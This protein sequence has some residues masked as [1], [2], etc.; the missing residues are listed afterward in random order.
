MDTADYDV[1]HFDPGTL[2]SGLVDLC[3]IDFGEHARTRDPANVA[4]LVRLVDDAQKIKKVITHKVPVGD[5]ERSWEE[6]LAHLLTREIPNHMWLAMG[7]QRF[8]LKSKWTVSL[9]IK[10]DVSVAAWARPRLFEWCEENGHSDLLANLRD[11][12][13]PKAEQCHDESA[14]L[15][16][17]VCKLIRQG[18]NVP[19]FLSV[20][21]TYVA[22]I[23]LAQA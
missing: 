12:S 6:L 17:L 10:P 1:G 16:R 19:Y 11:S 22:R 21:H 15:N 13:K 23:K 14:G 9:E 7:I 4:R 3:G 5:D 18:E 8:T 20:R 2:P